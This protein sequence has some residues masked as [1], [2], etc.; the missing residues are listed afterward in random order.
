MEF[1]SIEELLAWLVGGGLSI[2]VGWL[3]S[4][5]CQVWPWFNALDGMWKEFVSDGLAVVI[6]VAVAALLKYVPAPVFAEINAAWPVIL[7]LV[8]FVG[9]KLRYYNR[10]K[11]G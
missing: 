9:L 5:L 3:V 11:N 7:A 2:V 10:V 6:P 8:S 1:A 4:K